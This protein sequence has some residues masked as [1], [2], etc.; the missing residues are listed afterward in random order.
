M[1]DHGFSKWDFSSDMGEAKKFAKELSRLPSVVSAH[2][3]QFAMTSR[4][5]E[6][7]I[8]VIAF[9]KGLRT[10]ADFEAMSEKVNKYIA[11]S[12]QVSFE[13]LL[14]KFTYKDGDMI[15]PPF[16]HAFGCDMADEPP[17]SSSS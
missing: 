16:V 4:A 6:P 13:I 14:V 3:V 15:P 17:Q 8:G 11:K 7:K 2:V 9:T 1:P 10:K 12:N 5:P